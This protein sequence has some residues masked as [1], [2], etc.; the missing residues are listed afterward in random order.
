MAVEAPQNPGADDAMATAPAT[1]DTENV[2]I[3]SRDEVRALTV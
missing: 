3:V 1:L 2:D